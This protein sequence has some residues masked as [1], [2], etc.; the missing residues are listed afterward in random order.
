MVSALLLLFHLP[1]IHL[2]ECNKNPSLG[3][4]QSLKPRLFP[5]KKFLY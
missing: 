1:S 2:I 5:L 4:K 3:D